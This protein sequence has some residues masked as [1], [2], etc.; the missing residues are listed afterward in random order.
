[1]FFTFLVAVTFIHIA[2]IAAANISHILLV[3]IPQKI[4]DL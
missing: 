2:V 1:M 4:G 3:F